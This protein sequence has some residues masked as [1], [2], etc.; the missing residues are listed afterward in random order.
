MSLIL[1]PTPL[2][3]ATLACAEVAHYAA[4]VFRNQYSEIWNRAPETVAAELN[5]NVEQSAALLAL[6]EEAATSH[7][8]LLDQLA[9]L[10][11]EGAPNPFTNRAPIGMPPHWSFTDGVFSYNPPPPPPADPDQAP[12][13]EP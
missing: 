7:N 4:T 8:A 9:A 6:Y 12:L 1:T 3:R 13:P 5:A 10:L 2:Q 11:P